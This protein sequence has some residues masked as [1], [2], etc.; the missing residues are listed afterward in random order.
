MTLDCRSSFMPASLIPSA[1]A[2]RCTGIPD[3]IDITLAISSASTVCLFSF[4]LA[5]HSFFIS[6]NRRENSFSLS[7]KL[8]ASSKFCD[9]TASFFLLLASSINF[10]CSSISLGTLMLV[11]CTREPASSKASIA[12]SGKLRSVI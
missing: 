10:S 5:S 7:R 12:L 11:R 3:I 1:C 8:A 2:I 6:S 9:L 4:R